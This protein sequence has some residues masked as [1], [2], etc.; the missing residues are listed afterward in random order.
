MTYSEASELSIDEILLLNAALEMRDD[1]EN[2]R[3][4]HRLAKHHEFLA[5]LW[6]AK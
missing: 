3:L 5:K 2:N 1:I 4:D 6:G